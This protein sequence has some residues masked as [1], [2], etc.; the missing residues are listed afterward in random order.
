MGLEA[1]VRSYVHTSRVSV[2]FGQTQHAFLDQGDC[3]TLIWGFRIALIPHSHDQTEHSTKAAGCSASEETLCLL[4]LFLLF[5]ANGSGR[6]Y[7]RRHPAAQHA[8]LCNSWEPDGQ[9]V[10]IKTENAFGW[11]NGNQTGRSQSVIKA[12]GF[13][14]VVEIKTT[15][16]VKA[17]YGGVKEK[18]I[19]TMII[20]RCFIPT[21]ICLP[22]SCG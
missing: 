6:S 16:G 17:G 19:V 9:S 18:L 10:E 13:T 8:E 14:Q 7:S 12:I 4:L 15:D 21:V 11:V 20:A 22:P 3:C 2:V 5:K 1:E